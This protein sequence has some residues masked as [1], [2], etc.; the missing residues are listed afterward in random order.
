VTR[1]QLL[2]KQGK[3]DEARQLLANLQTSDPHDLALL[4]RTDA[5]LLFQAQRYQEAE[6]ALAKAT[7]S[8]PDDPDI[9]YDYAMSAEKNAHYG[10][11]EAQLRKLIKEQPDNPQAYNALGY[12]LVDRGLR[13]DEAEKLIEKAVSLAPNDAFIMDSLGWAKYRQGNPTEAAAILKKA[14][15][16]QP[17]A[18]IGAHLGEVQWKTGQQDAARNTWREAKKLEPSNDTLLKTLKRFQVNDL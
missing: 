11:M 3:V 5:A 4:A 2:A 14:Y 17:N 10:L 1:A 8:F 6:D 13:I 16:L 18:E 15:D 12:S 9:T 7:A